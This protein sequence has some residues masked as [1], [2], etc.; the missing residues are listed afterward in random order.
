MLREWL[1][2]V[3]L[4]VYKKTNKLLVR[5]RKT[6]EHVWPPVPGCLHRHSRVPFEWLS[7]LFEE[8][9]GIWN[10][11]FSA[12]SGQ[13]GAAGELIAIC[14]LCQEMKTFNKRDREALKQKTSRNFFDVATGDAIMG[15]PQRFGTDHHTFKETL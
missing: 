14:V 5:W 4:W 1:F 15:D 13:F 6:K 2:G 3:R 8:P 7:M 12:V 11:R 10:G 9:Q